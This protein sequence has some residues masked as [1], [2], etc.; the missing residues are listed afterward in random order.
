MMNEAATVVD[1]RSGD[2]SASLE[3]R[4]KAEEEVLAEAFRAAEVKKLA[5]PDAPHLMTYEPVSS[6]NQFLVP[7][8]PA[9]E[10]QTVS[11][12]DQ[13]S[14]SDIQTADLG[15]AVQMMRFRFL[16]TLFLCILN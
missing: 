14:P 9:P 6:L 13:K 3:V 16:C 8:P 10:V 2:G 11:V 15:S 5:V 4:I 12:Y 7:A 1:C